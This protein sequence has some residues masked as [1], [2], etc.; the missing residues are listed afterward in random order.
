MARVGG[1]MWQWNPKTDLEKAA[2]EAIA[3][4]ERT[5]GSK[6]AI[7]YVNESLASHPQE[8]AGV[9]IFTLSY[10]APAH[11]WLVE[12]EVRSGREKGDGT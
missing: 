2:G 4:Y 10:I 12:E 7:C 11:L 5:R 3:Y 9:R 1:M 8:V 6:P